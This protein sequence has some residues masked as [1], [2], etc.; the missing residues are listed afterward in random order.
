MIRFL[1]KGLLRDHSR[2]LFPLITVSVGVM[3]VVF[4]YCWLNGTKSEMIQTTAHYS[5][6]H[7][8]VMSRAYAQ[9]AE[10]IPNDLA[11]LDID[12]LLMELKR[13]F[14]ELIWTARIKFGG[15]IDIP[16]KNGETLKQA[17][18]NGLA[19]N[20]LSP[21]SPEWK[22]LNIEKS[23]VKGNLPRK[24]EEILIGDEFADKLNVQPGQTATLITSTMYGS[25]AMK[26]FT[27]VGTIRFGITAMDRM[28]MIADLTDIQSVLDM[29]GGAG[30][31]MG[32]F[33]DGIYHQERAETI[34]VLF[35]NRYEKPGDEFAP[36]MGTLYNQSGMGEYLNMIDLFSNIIITVFLLTMSIILWNAGLMGSL[37]RYGEIGVRLAIGEE[38]GHIYRSLLGTLAGVGISYYLQ[39]KGLDIS[40]MMKNATM[41]IS[42]IIRAKVT[43][44]SFVIG[45]LP[46][47]FAT[48]LG[49]LISGIG[50]YQRQ[51]SQLFKELEV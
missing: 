34:A 26:N 37:R 15:M 25:M 13:G 22:L 7:V 19:I 41:M 2:S 49:S 50:I 35:N 4:L 47:L 5:T 14:P 1:L 29:Q 30:E 31:I 46:G 28:A 51:T 8:R 6:G 43:P 42:N 20:L 36:V 40:Y 9:E 27:I 10:Q 24:P 44:S 32:F 23:L 11:L 21:A 3:L 12:T 38:K 39:V 33:H 17:P 48:F 18:V 45:F 16:D